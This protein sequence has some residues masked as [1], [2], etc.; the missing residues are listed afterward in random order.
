M[1]KYSESILSS[2]FLFYFLTAREK[3]L[4]VAKNMMALVENQNRVIGRI[5]AS[6]LIQGAGFKPILTHD[7]CNYA[8]GYKEANLSTVR[9]GEKAL[10]KKVFI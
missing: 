9:D 1:V 8:K 10:I 4:E 5:F 6:A 2:S 7:M 3:G